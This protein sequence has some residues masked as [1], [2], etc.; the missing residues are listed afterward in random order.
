MD[1]I[2]AA[3]VFITIVDQGSL[4]A[5]ANV[6]D[7]S[8]SMV[9]RYLAE[10]ETWADARLLHRT[11]RR[12]GLTP[13]GELV[14]RQCRQLV[15]VAEEL[16]AAGLTDEKAPAGLVR[17][18]CAQSL[19]CDVLDPFLQEYLSRYPATAIDLQ[20]SNYA[21]DMVEER[22]DLA[23][24]ITNDLDPNLIARPLGQ[25]RSVICA[26]T[27]YIEQYGKPAK[28]EDLRRHN[29]LGYS[30]F[31][32]LWHFTCAQ[33]E[34]VAVPVKGNF[35][36]SESGILLNRALAG[37]GISLQ[38]VYAVSAAIEQGRL[39]PLLTD[40]Q[41]ESLGI[42][43]IYRSRKHMAPALRV[44]LDELVEYFSAGSF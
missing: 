15:D 30:Y 8:R 11:T 40:Y 20:V 28:P 43:A 19:A 6:L 5:A 36:A 13:A 25:C 42:F 3:E 35:S 31:G 27:D 21:V 38:P 22:I 16:S 2:R 23:I 4:T 12:I 39:Q 14:L 33:G 17:I 34:P 7:M 10:M 44:L 9:T 26:S 18:S 37:G 24:R 29:C 1:R 41:V 32:N